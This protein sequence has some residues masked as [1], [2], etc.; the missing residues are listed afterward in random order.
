LATSFGN[1]QLTASVVHRLLV[2]G[3]YR[4]HL[5][6]MRAKLAD[7]MGE[8]MRRLNYAGLDVWTQPRAGMF[9]WARLP[10]SLDAA[11]IARHALGADVVFAPGNVFS[12]S[13]SATGYLRFNVSQCNRPKVYEA[14]QRAMESA[15]AS[16]ERK[17]A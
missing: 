12:V 8:T 9:V 6:S 15:A 14:L 13:Q 4:R 3:T 5:E 2:D 16:G 1:G 7:A 17:R 11:D 10:D